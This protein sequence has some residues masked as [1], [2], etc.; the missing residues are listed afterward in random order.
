VRDISEQAAGKEKA[1]TRTVE[2]RRRLENSHQSCLC[3]LRARCAVCDPMSP[4][5]SGSRD[6]V[7]RTRRERGR[8]EANGKKIYQHAFLKAIMIAFNQQ[9]YLDTVI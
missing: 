5:C 7:G 1:R 8:L 6:A 2:R 4:E 3:L 9:P